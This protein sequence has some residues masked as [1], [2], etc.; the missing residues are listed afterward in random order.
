MVSTL[1]SLSFSSSLEV[2]L[3]K[4]NV[5]KGVSYQIIK[6]YIAIG[7]VELPGL[8]NKPLSGFL[9]ISRKSE[10]IEGRGDCSSSLSSGGKRIS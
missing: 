10:F 4:K 9:L 7:G 2:P 3:L 6:T 5:K 1:L 8:F